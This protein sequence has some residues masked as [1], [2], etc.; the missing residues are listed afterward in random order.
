VDRWAFSSAT[1]VI[2][3]AA[4]IGALIGTRL[5]SR[6]P[7]RQLREAF[8]ALVVVVAAYLIVTAAFLGGPPRTS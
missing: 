4:L 8:G 5:A 3:A 6:V 2:A 7:Q 1:F